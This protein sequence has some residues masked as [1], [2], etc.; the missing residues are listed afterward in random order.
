M[1]E[2]ERFIQSSKNLTDAEIEN[3]LRP[4]SFDEYVGQTKV[5]ESLNVYIQAAKS[6]KESLYRLS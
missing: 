2:E 4:T 1:K 6:R 3:S 5:K